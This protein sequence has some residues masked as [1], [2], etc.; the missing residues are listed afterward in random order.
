MVDLRRPASAIEAALSS[1]GQA[2]PEKAAVLE[3]KGPVPVLCHMQTVKQA[4]AR[5]S[6]G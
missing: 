1:P 3:M 6:F 2:G 4:A 5:A